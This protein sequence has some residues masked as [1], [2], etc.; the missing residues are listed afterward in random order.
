MSSS[1]T[2]LLQPGA[3]D[4][5]ASSIADAPDRLDLDGPEPGTST[6]SEC[7]W[8]KK[9]FTW[10]AIGF[11]LV[12]ATIS[13]GSSFYFGLMTGSTTGDPLAI[14]LMSRLFLS[15]LENMV[16]VSIAVGGA[17]IPMATGLIGP[18]PALGLDRGDKGSS[19]EPGFVHQLFWCFALCSFGPFVSWTWWKGYT[20]LPFPYG[21]ALGE[22]IKPDDA[23]RH[24]GL[25]LAATDS[26]QERKQ[27]RP[28]CSGLELSWNCFTAAVFLSGL[29]VRIQMP[30]NFKSSVANTSARNT[31]DDCALS[32]LPP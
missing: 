30:L 1:R 23:P 29:W 31:G 20:R 27:Q 6:P 19:E 11:G 25:V 13:C 10:R 12:W 32:S 15:P 26:V 4:S 18:L 2:P 14:A 7:D 21:K 22:V 5:G 24:D 28:S 3:R 9:G 8:W 16:V 17:A